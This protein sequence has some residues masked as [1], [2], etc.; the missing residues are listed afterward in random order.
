ME[1]PF[2]QGWEDK[3]ENWEAEICPKCKD[4]IGKIEK[5]WRCKEDN[6]TYHD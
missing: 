1:G 4:P 6:E 5:V 3:E 2:T